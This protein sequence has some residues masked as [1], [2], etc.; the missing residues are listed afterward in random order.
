[1]R[2]IDEQ[3]IDTP[4]YVARQMAC[5]PLRE[6]SASVASGIDCLMCSTGLS[7]IYQKPNI[8]Q[9]SYLYCFNSSL[10]S[11]WIFKTHNLVSKKDE[12]I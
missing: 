1:M 4:Y 6:V 2:L 8:R 7:G 12:Y 11:Q 3:L 10:D 5:H 9:Y